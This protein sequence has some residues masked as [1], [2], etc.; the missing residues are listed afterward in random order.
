MNLLTVSK[1]TLIISV[2][3]QLYHVYILPHWA[4][5]TAS[6]LCYLD[7]FIESKGCFIA[8]LM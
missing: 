6:I 7:V 5:C 1:S 4:F 2:Y 3:G 8:V